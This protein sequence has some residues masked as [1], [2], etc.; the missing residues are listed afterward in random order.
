MPISNQCVFFLSSFPQMSHQKSQPPH[1][2]IFDL[3]VDIKYIILNHLDNRSL[4]YLSQTCTYFGKLPFTCIP[5]WPALLTLL[6]SNAGA[7]H[8][9]V[10]RG[11]CQSGRSLHTKTASILKLPSRSFSWINILHALY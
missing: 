11:S 1:T 5:K 10:Q 6:N 9:L 2:S 4:A 3:S 7:E 8:S